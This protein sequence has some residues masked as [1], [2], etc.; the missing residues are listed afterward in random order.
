MA[1]TESVI[2]RVS[3]KS[4]V[5]DL[6]ARLQGELVE[7][8]D[9]AYGQARAVWNGRADRQPALIV[10][11]ADAVDVAA[12]VAF[13]HDQNVPV[14][15]RSGSH[16][17][18][19]Y[20]VCDGG[21]VIDLSRMKGIEI[22]ADRRVARVEA[23][24]TWG[25]VAAATQPYG[26]AI[27]A[28]D[29]ATVGVGGLSLGGGIGWMV[30]KH[31]LAIDNMRSVEVVTADGRFLRASATEHAELFWGLRGGGGNFGI[32]TAFEFDLHPAGMILGG[33]VLY[34]VSNAADAEDILR[35]Y[36]RIA[37]DA[38]DELTT[39][40]VLMQAPPAPFIP[41]ERQG[42]PSVAIIVCYAGDPAEGEQV[43]A[44][45]RRLGTPLADIIAPM[46]YSAIFAL[47]AEGE[48]PGLRHY[49]RSLFMRT[50]DEG[51][52]RA[53]ATESAATMSPGTLVQLRVMGGAMGRVPADATAF[54]HRDAEYAVMVTN[55]GPESEGDAARAARTERLWQALRPYASG[56]YVNFL[57]DEGE[58]RIREAYPPA[59]YDRLAAL[60]A[61]YDPTNLFRLNQNIPPADAEA[62]P[63]A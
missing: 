60:K 45:L 16:S 52:L 48:V 5:A 53:L 30:R 24:L 59:T 11:C 40:A 29:T 44:P 2:S 12:A 31:G 14:A 15:V 34:D 43:V 33:A 28:G 36:A 19:G 23:G 18:A 63:T 13:A 8:D 61:Q 50:L 39:Q 37:T 3:W 25:E 17:I 56:V 7:P 10:R 58:S 51:A 1:I 49:V 46:P 41:V 26:L 20:S 4:G 42:T 54:A 22:D 27:T 38:P 47:T 9:A 55:F 21:V 35:A 57:G 6:R 62:L 32:A